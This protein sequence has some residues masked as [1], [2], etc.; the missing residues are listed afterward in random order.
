MA[1]GP[2]AGDTGGQRSLSSLVALTVGVPAQLAA[3]RRMQ[4]T[5]SLVEGY[6]NLVM[7]LVGRR[8]LPGFSS[9]EKAYARRSRERSPLEVLLWR[10]TGLELKLR[11]YRL[12]EAFSRTIHDRHGMAV[13]NRAWESADTLPRPEELRDPDG[14]YRRVILGEEHDV[15]RIAGPMRAEST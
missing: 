14:W 6:G 8:L 12:G 9:L 15:H 10:L 7:N 4:A 11:Q 1:A 3:V 13:L 2:R 5:M